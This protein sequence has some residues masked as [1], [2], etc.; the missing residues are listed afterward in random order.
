VA[1]L[2][3]LL[4]ALAVDTHTVTPKRPAAP[5]RLT[6][7]EVATR[8]DVEQ[9]LGRPVG[10]GR[11]ETWGAESNC[12]YETSEGG[13]VTITL[14]Q[15][16][17]RPDLAVET[18]S[19]MRETPEGKVREAADF[20]PDAFFLEIPAAGAQLHLIRGGRQHLMVSVLGLGEPSLASEVAAAIARKAL[21]RL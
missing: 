18:A 1:T 9:A 6:A 4:A 5:L 11:A 16:S 20:G 19:L 21:T 14:Q 13:M 8:M 15:L 17:A 7:C 12:D 10:R 2:L 3:L